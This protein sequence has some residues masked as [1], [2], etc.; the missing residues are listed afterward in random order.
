LILHGNYEDETTGIEGSPGVE[1]G[2]WL[3][4]R[5][6][7][8]LPE[9]WWGSL[10]AALCGSVAAGGLIWG[11]GES[12]LRLA[13]VLILAD[14][15]IAN[16]SQLF[17]Q[18]AP[19]KCEPRRIKQTVPMLPYTVAG[20]PGFR[21]ARWLQRDLGRARSLWSASAWSASSI[22]L[23]GSGILAIGWLLGPPALWLTLAAVAAASASAIIGRRYESAAFALQAAVCS[24]LPWIIAWAAFSPLTPA[25]W[26]MAAL[27][28]VAY[29]AA[30]RLL[31]DR[32]Q[33]SAAGMTVAITGM[34]LLLVVI[35]QPIWAAFVALLGAFP[36]WLAMMAEHI[37]G[38]AYV[39]RTR[40]YLLAITLT[41]AL[42]LA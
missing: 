3:S 23:Q 42:A 21:L 33:G 34:V 35:R 24:G 5:V 10:W 13:L 40:Y 17:R 14:P 6:R 27:V 36:V 2:T 29:W 22:I 39:R 16:W 30:R 19:V 20:S 8:A 41:T 15:L 1:G 38:S 12:M 18:T 11:D 9:I 25:A 32:P 31:V 7:F 37:T 28:T 26:G 4:V